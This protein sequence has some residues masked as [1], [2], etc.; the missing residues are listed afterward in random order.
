MGNISFITTAALGAMLL[1]G[2]VFS[3]WY[4]RHDNMDVI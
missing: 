4:A 3:I 2:F 1:V